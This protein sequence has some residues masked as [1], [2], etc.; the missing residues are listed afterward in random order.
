MSVWYDGDAQDVGHHWIAPHRIV[1]HTYRTIAFVRAG[2]RSCL[3]GRLVWTGSAC[4]VALGAGATG[5]VPATPAVP[6]SGKGPRAASNEEP[7]LSSA[8]LSSLAE[9][10]IPVV[11]RLAVGLCVAHRAG[12]NR[13]G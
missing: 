3:M 1:E 6:T 10:A 7:S 9:A 4:L 8:R 5:P 12:V 11:N 2:V 13:L